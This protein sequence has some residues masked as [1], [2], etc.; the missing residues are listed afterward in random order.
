MA[1]DAFHERMKQ[2][3]VLYV[4]VYPYRTAADGSPEFLLL[5]RNES[6]ELAGTWQALSGKMRAGEKISEAMW[7]QSEDKLGVVPKRLFK[8]DF[9]NTFYDDYYD[10]VMMVPTAACELEGHEVVSVSDLHT[11]FC[12]VGLDELP[13]YFVWPNQLKVAAMIADMLARGVVSRFHEIARP[14]PA[15]A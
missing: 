11:E 6:V 10:T 15:Q 14:S 12:W 3:G 4:D 8:V 9:V 5:R 2:V 13:Q 7:R 1:I